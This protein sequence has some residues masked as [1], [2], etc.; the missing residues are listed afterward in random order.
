MKQEGADTKALGAAHKAAK[1]DVERF[2]AELKENEKG[3][4]A[5]S[6]AQTAARAELE[7]IEGVYGKQAAALDKLDKELS[8]SGRDT[9]DLAKLQ[10]GLATEVASATAAIEKQAKAVQSESQAT[11]TLKQ[12]LLDGDDAMRKFAQSGT[13]SAEALK[14]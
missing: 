10:D 7:K 4:K 1:D 5:F 2:G 9:K 13:A 3:I 12:R 8:E 14:R 6:A 11:A